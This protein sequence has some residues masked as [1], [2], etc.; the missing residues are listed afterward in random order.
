MWHV[1]AA[2]QGLHQNAAGHSRCRAACRLVWLW[3]LQLASQ[4]PFRRCKGWCVLKLGV[5]WLHNALQG[6]KQHQHIS[7]Q[8]CFSSQ[9]DA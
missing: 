3:T 1:Q 2:G 8:A 6:R 5:A 7:D 9:C 4:G